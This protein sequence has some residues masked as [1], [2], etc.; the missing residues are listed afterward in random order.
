MYTLKQ[1]RRWTHLIDFFSLERKV[2]RVTP[3]LWCPT[4]TPYTWMSMGKLNEPEKLFAIAYRGKQPVAR[5]GFKVHRAH[6]Y[7]ALHFGYFEALPDTHE[8]VRA[9]VELG[10]QLA[11]HLPMRGPHHFRLEDPYTGLLVDGFDFEPHFL[12]SYNPPYYQDLL[13]GAGLNKSMDLYT[14]RYL[15]TDIKPDIMKGRADRAATKGI[16]VEPMRSGDLRRQVTQIAEVFNDALSQNWGFEPIEGAQLE[17]LM[18]LA[19]FVLDPNMV[20]LAYQNSHPIGCIIVLPNLN[21]MLRASNGS[22]NPKFMWKYLT[23]NRWVD[24][25]RGYA[26]GVRKEYRADEVTAALINAA[27]ERGK[28]IHW[29]E[30]E[31]SWVLES[32]RPMNA[33][34]QAL[35]GKR[36]KTYRLLERPPQR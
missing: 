7:E 19:R 26:L 30:L 34:A 9:L 5:A 2:Y 28:Q 21:P 18:L 24:S 3:G 11:P 36:N 1:I 27:M 12:M 22:L 14:Y 15:N 16:V 10:H 35:G 33:L 31:I 32:N 17:D 25:Y 20:F 6:G 29:R 4:L 13:A 23:R 8:E